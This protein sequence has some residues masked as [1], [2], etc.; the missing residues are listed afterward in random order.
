MKINIVIHA[1][2][3]SSKLKNFN[4]ST[5]KGKNLVQ[6]CCEKLL[7]SKNINEVY[8]DTESSAIENSISYLIP[9][10]LK[11]LK[12]PIEMCCDSIVAND[13]LVHSLH[14]VS[15]CDVL[16]Q[17]FPTSPL[18]SIETI[19]NAIKQFI[20]KL[21]CHDSFFITSSS[22][23]YFWNNKN[24]PTPINFTTKKQPRSNKLEVI[25]IETHGLYGTTVESLI[26][27]KR[28]IGKNPMMIE[29]PKIES[30]YVRDDQDLKI[31]KKLLQEEII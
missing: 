4:L 22:Q 28:R 19:D 31:V 8:L 9:K 25:Y 23:E 15:E 11:I 3:R 10:G 17:T 5:I 2:G 16:L 13:L 6:I 12:R 26:E 29:V 30:F 18:L 27:N 7:K 21:D 1:K 14:S 24:N 20:N